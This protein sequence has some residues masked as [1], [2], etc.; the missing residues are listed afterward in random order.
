MATTSPG[1]AA[2][3]LLASAIAVGAA[4]T[5]AADPAAPP[6]PDCAHAPV[7][8]RPL[9]AAGTAGPASPSDA[10]LALVAASDASLDL[11]RGNLVAAL[12]EARDSTAIVTV[13]ASDRLV[14]VAHVTAH[15]DGGWKVDALRTCA[16]AGA[17]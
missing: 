7:I 1:R 12:E 15:P 3:V 2:R 9:Y 5:F 6:L 13:H 4:L 14:G 16:A 11:G 8:L 10:V 17:R